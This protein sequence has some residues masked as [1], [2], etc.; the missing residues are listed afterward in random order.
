[1]SLLDDGL[2]GPN[3]LDGEGNVQGDEMVGYQKGGKRTRWREAVVE[4]V[5]EAA[6]PLSSQLGMQLSKRKNRR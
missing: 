2:D 3:S 1:M 6:P 5:V 4:A